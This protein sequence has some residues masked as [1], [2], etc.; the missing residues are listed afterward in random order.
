[1]QD[2][3]TF[4]D[5]GIDYERKSLHV[6]LKKNRLELR[7]VESISSV[8]QVYRLT[9]RLFQIYQFIHVELL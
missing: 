9:I 3:G 5:K 1:M 4:K 2:S 6:R 8:S 7:Y